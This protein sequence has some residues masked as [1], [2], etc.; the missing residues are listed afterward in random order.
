[1]QGHSRSGFRAGAHPP[2]RLDLPSKTSVHRLLVALIP[3][4]FQLDPESRHAHPDPGRGASRAGTVSGSWAGLGYRGPTRELRF[5][6]RVPASRSVREETATACPGRPDKK[7][8][9]VKK[10]TPVTISELDVQPISDDELRAF[11][12]LGTAAD[13]NSEYICCNGSSSETWISCSAS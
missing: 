1:R 10:K 13:F 4:D 7:G 9:V 3:A 2:V 5:P 6:S 12:A 11:E 8:V